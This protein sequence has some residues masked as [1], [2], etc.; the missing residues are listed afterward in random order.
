MLLE[1]WDLFICKGWKVI[2]QI[3]ICILDSL[4]EEIIEGS[5]DE[6]MLTLA[7]ISNP[8][9]QSAIFHHDFL[10]RA[11]KVKVSSAILGVLEAEYSI[12]R[13][14]ARTNKIVK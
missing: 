8:R 1:I 11:R 6:I 14:Y 7:T 9:K 13:A 4:K 12:I 5:F 3:A 2:F 10:A